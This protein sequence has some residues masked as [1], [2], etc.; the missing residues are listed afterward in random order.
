M[1]Q[2]LDLDGFG[3]FVYRSVLVIYLFNC[4]DPYRSFAFKYSALGVP[5]FGKFRKALRTHGIYNV[6]FSFFWTI[7]K[8]LLYYN[9]L[10]FLALPNPMSHLLY[11]QKSTVKNEH[12]STCHRVAIN[13][14]QIRCK[15][16]VNLEIVNYENLKENKRLVKAFINVLLCESKFTDLTLLSWCFDKLFI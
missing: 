10:C 6:L 13:N 4:L 12:N 16:L 2:T 15:S 14:E 8:C 11:T 9:L 5:D 7:L 1:P 3:Y